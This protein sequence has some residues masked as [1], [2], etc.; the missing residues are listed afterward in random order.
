MVSNPVLVEMGE[1]LEKTTED[2]K[3]IA[4][5]KGLFMDYVIG[6][7]TVINATRGGS[8]LIKPLYY[9]NADPDRLVEV[10]NNLYDNAVK[11]TEKGK[12]IIGLTGNDKVVQ[13]Y[14]KDTGMG[15]PKDDLAHLFQKFYRV[16][17]TDTRLVGGSGLGLF[18]SRKIIEMYN[19][20]IWAE[21]EVGK[22]TTFFIN[23]PR[24][25]TQQAQAMQSPGTINPTPKPVNT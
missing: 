15:I 7:N 14:I 11:Y 22:G 4:E 20:R 13:F 19:G 16:D 3:M 23:L 24:L 18:I 5:K 9:V 25:T 10:I 12:V 21:S 8:Q 1:L 17:S 6:S 2:L